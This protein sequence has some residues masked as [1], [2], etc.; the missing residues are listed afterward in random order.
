LAAETPAFAAGAPLV[1]SG[2]HAVAQAP[3]QRLELPLSASNRYSV[4]PL[5]STRILPRS[6]F[7][8]ATDAAPEAVLVLPA[9]AVPE[10]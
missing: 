3:S 2:G 1:V 5:P 4:R 8:T 10:P 6:E 9:G 7:A